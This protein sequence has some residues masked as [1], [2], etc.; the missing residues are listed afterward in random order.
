MS[1]FFLICNVN[2]CQIPQIKVLFFDAAGTLFQV[3]GSVADVYLHYAEKYGVTPSPKLKDSVNTAFRQAFRDAPP[4]VFAVNKIEE[5]K[6]SERLWWFDIVHA[7]FYRVGMFEGFDEYFEEVYEAFSGG[8]HWELYPETCSVLG[9]LK[10][11]GYE[12]GIISN[13]DTRLFP[14]IRDLNIHEMFDSVT[15]S[16]LAQAAKP[17]KGIFDY[18]LDQHV[19]DPEEAVHVGDSQ[20]EDFE[21]ARQANLK[22]VLIRREE[23]GIEHVPCIH[24]LE[25][26][27]P[28]L[29][30]P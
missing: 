19:L 28:F 14:I 7:V 21:G 5:L 13:F 3:K 23:K 8:K 10:S 24:S 11:Q 26:I 17:A 12:L 15:I 29:D 30:Q 6:Q 20:K 27:F 2:S 18:A 22:A 9:Q 4:P 25:E 1:P 16:S